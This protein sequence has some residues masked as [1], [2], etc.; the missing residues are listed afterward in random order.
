MKLKKLICLVAY[1]G[2]AKYLPAS[3]NP[4]THWARKIRYAI[5]RPVFDCCG[6]NVN[7]EQG[8]GFGTGKKIFIGSG[9]GLGVNCSVHGPLRIGDNVMMGPNV[10]ILTH[11]HE[12]GRTDIPMCKQGSIIKEVIIGN[13]VWIG[14]CSI[15]MPGV[16]I[17]NGVVIGAGSVVTKDV[18]DY[19]V[20]G[21]VPAKI[22]KL[23]R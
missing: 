23:R 16:K 7:I 13:D 18:P 9:S 21:G 15:I 4:M 11:K 17:G 14:M 10:T 20:V 3:T 5:A 1:Y 6:K 12:I 8:A 2:F 22:I 19:A